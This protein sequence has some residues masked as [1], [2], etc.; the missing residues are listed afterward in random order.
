MQV[1]RREEIEINKVH[2]HMGVEARQPGWCADGRGQTVFG[3]AEAVTS[4][5]STVEDMATEA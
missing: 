5:I 2:E 3:C 4:C 1:Y